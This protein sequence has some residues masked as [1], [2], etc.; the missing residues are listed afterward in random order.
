MATARRRF[1]ITSIVVNVRPTTC[2]SAAGRAEAAAFQV[3]QRCPAAAK[4]LTPRQQQ[5]LVRRP[6]TNAAI[7]RCGSS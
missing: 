7:Y 1:S 6:A 5:A 3:G 4:A 2:A